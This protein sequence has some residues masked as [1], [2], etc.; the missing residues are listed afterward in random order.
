M[1]KPTPNT[2]YPIRNTGHLPLV[3]IVG[4][5]AS[6]KSALALKLAQQIKGEIICAD[7]RTIYKGMDMGTAK[8]TPDERRLVPHHLLDLVEANDSFNVADFKREAVAAIS[9]IRGRGK[10]PIM[11]GGSGLYVDAVIFDYQFR[12]KYDQKIR[13]ALA[14]K[15]VDELIKLALAQGISAG[16]VTKNRRHLVRLLEGGPA[17]DSDRK[18]M[19]EDVTLV[20]LALPRAQLR[21]NITI[22]IETMFKRG[23]KREVEGL[24]RQFS[25]QTE[26]LSGIGYREFEDYFYKRAS[27]ASVKRQIIQH[28][29]NLAKRQRTWLKR[30][31][32]IKWF[33]SAEAAEQFILAQ[34][35]RRTV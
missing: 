8:P 14:A 10:L 35:G 22:R 11:V 29:L 24:S 18:T 27:L 2:Q 1:N 30:N 16:D 20:G 7:S 3:V 9:D 13:H 31:P 4:E 32:R 12:E 17:S 15:S 23:L 25:W 19:I 21:R 26:A 28:T 33:D 34:L 5:T 6:G